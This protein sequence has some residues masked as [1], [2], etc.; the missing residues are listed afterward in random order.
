MKYA[1]IQRHRGEFA[2]RLMCRVL[3]VSPSGFYASQRRPRSARHW[4]D[5]QLTTQIRLAHAHSRRTYGA[6][7]VHE[8]L[9]ATGESVARKRVARLMHDDGLAAMVKRRYVVTTDSAHTHPIAA[10]H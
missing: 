10:N 2:V 9:K 8:E 7:R 6:P 4:R 1:C 5:Q 3:A